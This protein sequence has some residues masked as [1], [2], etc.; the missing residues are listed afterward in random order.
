M[1]KTINFRTL[2]LY[3]IQFYYNFLGIIK[4]NFRYTTIDE[5]H[6]NLVVKYLIQT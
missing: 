4:A 2:A 3:I 1:K 5:N 6:R